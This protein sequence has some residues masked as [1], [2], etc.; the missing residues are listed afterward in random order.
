MGNPT[1]ELTRHQP[2]VFVHHDMVHIVQYISLTYATATGYH[3]WPT[4]SVSNQFVMHMCSAGL[5]AASSTQQ[6]KHFKS[7][8]SAQ[9]ADM[10]FVATMLLVQG[11]NP[12]GLFNGRNVFHHSAQALNFWVL[13]AGHKLNQYLNIH[14]VRDL[15]QACKQVAHSVIKVA[16]HTNHST[17]VVITWQ[18][19]RC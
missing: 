9:L 4:T 14:P 5:P 6:F 12:L 15:K 16:L 10:V 7:T 2:L 17:C 13:P 3:G 11:K 18:D 1:K 8:V 19:F